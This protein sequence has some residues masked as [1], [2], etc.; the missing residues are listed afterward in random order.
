[1]THPNVQG[2]VV[3]QGSDVVEPVD[4]AHSDVGGI[5]V[6]DNAGQGG[7]DEEGYCTS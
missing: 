5:V 3:E 7:G 2:D 1:M 4:H 6:V